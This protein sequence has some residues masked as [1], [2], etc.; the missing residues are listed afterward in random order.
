MMVKLNYES[1][2]TVNQTITLMPRLNYSND[3]LDELI[4]KLKSEI[5]DIKKSNRSL[6]IEFDAT[7]KDD[8]D[9]LELERTIAFSLE[10]LEY[11]QNRMNSISDISSIP[12][13]ISSIVPVLR[14]VSSKLF[15][16]MPG[17]SQKLCE[18]SIYLGSVVLDSATLI[19]AKFDFSQS[20]HESSSVLDE[21]KLI[22][23]SKINKQYPN[24]DFFKP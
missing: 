19:N 4:T 11:V 16:I 14:T 12:E 17:C 7:D 6:L 9:A 13:K 8:F 22:V 23:D 3:L 5:K 24:L 1:K 20:N 15:D 2:D 10:I 21:V 18:L